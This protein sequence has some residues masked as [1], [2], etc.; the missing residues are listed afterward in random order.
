[1]VAR[2]MMRAAA[3]L[4]ALPASA[5]V[6]PHPRLRAPRVL[7]SAPAAAPPTADSPPRCAVVAAEVAD[8]GKAVDV[9]FGSGA[10]YRFHALWL[11]DACRDEA[12]VAAAAGERILMMLPSRSRQDHSFR[13]SRCRLA[14]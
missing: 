7:R 1:M 8:G 13:L 12:H 4:L 3:A 11:R 14:R 10:T 5:L 6:A 9:S 2:A